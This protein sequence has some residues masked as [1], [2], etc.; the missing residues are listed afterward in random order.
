MTAT[1]TTTTGVA[2]DAPVCG[3]GVWLL[4]GDGPGPLD[5]FRA[6]LTHCQQTPGHRGGHLVVVVGEIDDQAAAQAVTLT[7][8]NPQPDVDDGEPSAGRPSTWDGRWLGMPDIADR[9]GVSRPWV[10]RLRQLPDFPPRVARHGNRDFWP[11]AVIEAWAAR[12]GRRLAP[13]QE[14]GR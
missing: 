6:Y 8:P 3:A 1:D 10:R 4:A 12:T 11:E 2:G 5:E 14:T 7:W 13:A 9:L